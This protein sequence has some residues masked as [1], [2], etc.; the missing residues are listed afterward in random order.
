MLY[1]LATVLL[2]P[3]FFLQGR[4]VRRVTPVLP[5]PEGARAGQ[6]GCGPALSLLIVGDSAAAG[7]GVAH[8]QL[9]LSGSLLARLSES[10][11]VR[12][13]LLAKSGDTSAQLLD[14]LSRSGCGEFDTVVV[15]VGVND[16]T[17]LTRSKRWRENLQAIIAELQNRFGARRIYFSCVPPMHAFPALPQPLRWW[18]GARAHRLNV[19]MQRVLDC[20]EGCAFV[21]VPY[22][23][24]G[25]YIAADGFH[26]GPQA[27][28]LWG[29]HVAELIQ[30]ERSRCTSP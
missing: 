21:Q 29:G 2:G 27:Y 5:E 6:Q 17:A 19:Q 24:V 16:V 8:Q 22:P 18:L 1:H 23:A 30:S 14:T 15:S 26:P 28:Q 20:H 10:H 3:V 13:T 7:V 25:A 9:A 4:Y 12:W 11:A